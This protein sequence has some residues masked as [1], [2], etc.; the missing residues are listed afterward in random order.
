MPACLLPA[1][2]PWH[3]Q[4]SLEQMADAPL[5]LVEVGRHYDNASK[6]VNGTDGVAVILPADPTWLSPVVPTSRIS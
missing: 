5:Q 2:P 6:E 4:H 1:K 3:H